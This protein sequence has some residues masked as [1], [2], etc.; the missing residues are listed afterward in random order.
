MKQVDIQ[1]K[2]KAILKTQ[3]EFKFTTY[4]QRKLTPHF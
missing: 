3:Q 4:K 1:G 2:K